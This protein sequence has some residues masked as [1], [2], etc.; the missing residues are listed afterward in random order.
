[1]GFLDSNFLLSNETG[2]ALYHDVAADL[3][4]V[5]AHNH[6]WARQIADNHPITSIADLW[7]AEDHYKWRLMRA[8]GVEESLVTG[9]D[10]PRARF[11][12]FAA[13]LAAAP[14][15]PLYVWSH[16]EL[17]R[18][19]GIET[20]LGPATADAVYDAANERLADGS[21]TPAS[22]L[23]S[24]RA[25]VVC[26]TDDPAD[27]LDAHGTHHGVKVLPTFR[28]DAAADVSDPR[29]FDR[30]VTRL[31]ESI[32]S[33]IDSPLHFREALEQ[34]HRDFHEAG[35]RASDHGLPNLWDPD[36]EGHDIDRI[37]QRVRAGRVPTP[38]EQ[39]IFREW[40]L[41]EVARLNAEAG[42]VSQLHV[43]P[44]RNLRTRLAESFGPDAGADAVGNAIN[45]EGLASF[46]NGR[47]RAGCLPKV[48]I[49][50]MRPE[51]ARAA[52]SVAGVFNG[53]G[54]SP[55]SVGSS[56][57][58]ATPAAAHAQ[59][60]PGR[61]Q[62]GPAWWFAD[63]ESG[64]RAQIRMLGETG[65]LGHANGMVTDS[66]SLLSLVRHEY[67]RRILCDELGRDVERGVLPDDHDLLGRWVRDIAYE[68]A[69]CYFGFP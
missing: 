1:M 60:T 12:A 69:L 13:A 56:P 36:F 10:D 33:P 9:S 40:V 39:V 50:T 11:R 35:C 14:M 45:V 42:W 55:G 5:D 46:L 63:T 3:P 32:G 8:H 23:A 62:V 58:A 26:T 38:A 43:G 2:A 4:I 59:S 47:D 28:P 19:F 7:L 65:S 29:R 22:L 30:Y 52:A 49:Y 31:A 37:W 17:R 18:V 67:F 54:A 66:R 20:V 53:G 27:D 24:F 48:T 61:I 44:I 68:N 34:R 6:L 15:N 64:I 16:L 41:Q 25:E 51:D 57:A 21:L